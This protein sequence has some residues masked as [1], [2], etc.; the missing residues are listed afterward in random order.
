[1][2]GAAGILGGMFA[3]SSFLEK[4]ALTLAF[5]NFTDTYL[6]TGDNC[7]ILGIILLLTA[8]EIFVILSYE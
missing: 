1:M 6:A 2:G 5:L 4:Q 8:V 3:L 7:F